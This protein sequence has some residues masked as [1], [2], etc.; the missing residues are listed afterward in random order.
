[1]AL[2]EEGTNDAEDNDG[3][4]GD[5]NP[6]DYQKH[7]KHHSNLYKK[8]HKHKAICTCTKC[9]DPKPPTAR[10]DK[11]RIHGGPKQ[12]MSGYVP[13]CKKGCFAEHNCGFEKIKRTRGYRYAAV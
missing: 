12:T 9:S 13:F 2:T 5:D 4:E 10:K 11:G 8:C 6:E 7:P 3:G 1:M